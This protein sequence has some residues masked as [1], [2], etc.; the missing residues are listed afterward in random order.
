MKKIQEDFVIA[1]YQSGIEN[2]AAFTREVGLWASEEHVFHKYLKASDHILDLGCG[3]G[4]TTFSLFDLGYT[5]IIGVDLTPEMIAAAEQIKAER[6]SNLTFQVG[7]AK[8]LSFAN[9]VFD[10]VIFSFNGLMS[11]PDS[12][13]RFKAVQEIYR[14]LKEDG[15]FIFTTH[16]REQDENYFNFWREEKA[17]WEKGVQSQELYEFGDIIATSKNEERPIFIHIPNQKEVQDFLERGGFSILETFYRNEK[18]EESVQV[19]E[20]SGE[21][22]FWVARKNS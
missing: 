18:F 1:Q 7:N 21:C 13:E 19:K 12:A 16:D 4:R 5:S 14:V 20:K 17:R 10:V 2:Y 3:T 15:L 8:A 22:R 6:D 9:A 11:I